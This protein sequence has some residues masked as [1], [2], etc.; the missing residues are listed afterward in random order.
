VL[1]QSHLD[2][3]QQIGCLKFS[4]MMMQVYAFV[5]VHLR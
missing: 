5:A 1:G 2:A 4:L 3:L